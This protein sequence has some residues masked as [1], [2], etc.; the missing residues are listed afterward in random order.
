MLSPLNCRPIR[1]LPW[2]LARRVSRHPHHVHQARGRI[3]PS[4]GSRS[5]FA[6]ATGWACARPCDAI[7]VA[8]LGSLN[9][10]QSAIA[11]PGCGQYRGNLPRHHAGGGRPHRSNTELLAAG[12]SCGVSSRRVSRATLL[13]ALAGFAPERTR[14]ARAPFAPP[15]SPALRRHLNSRPKA[16]AFASSIRQYRPVA[17]PAN[18]TLARVF[19][20]ERISDG[21]RVVVKIGTDTP[22]HD[23]ALARKILQAA[24]PSSRR[25]RAGHR[26][27]IS[28]PASPGS[29]PYVVIEYLGETDLRSRLT[30]PSRPIDAIRIV[31]RIL[32]ALDELHS[33]R[34]AHLDLKPENIFSR[35]RQS[36]ADRF[37]YLRRVWRPGQ[38]RR[39]R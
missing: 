11:A 21:T 14:T 5:V 25:A 2:W 37:Q 12:A 9:E 38:K 39:A 33:G 34:I 3:R 19:L 7:V 17:P 13:E 4:R 20:S 10:A 22:Y 31:Q 26:A 36:G 15:G 1:A 28:T 27:A 6:N 16:S 30:R 29:W 18:H 23:P 8:G 35:R 24:T 32:T